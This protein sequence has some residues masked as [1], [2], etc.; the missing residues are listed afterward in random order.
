M[1]EFQESL[2]ELAERPDLDAQGCANVLAG[3]TGRDLL[4]ALNEWNGSGQLDLNK[5]CNELAGTSG[6][7]AQHAMDTLATA[8]LSGGEPATVPATPAAPTAT[9]GNQLATLTFSAPAN[10]GSPITGYTA[11]STPGGVTASGAAS[12]L[13]VTGLTNGTPYTF[14]VRATNAVGDSAESPASNSVTPAT[15][16]G[17]PTI[18]T[19]TAGDTQAT[20]P[21]TA[22][23]SN[24]GEAI[25]GY[26]A[27]SSPGGLTATGAS[28]PLTVTGLTNGQ[29]YTFTVKATNAVGDSAD[30]AASNSVTPVATITNL[31]TANQSSIETNTSGLQGGGN[32][33]VAQSLL[34]A[35]HGN[36]SLRGTNTSAGTQ[37]LGTT[38]GL[39]GRPVSPNTQYTAVADVRHGGTPR[40]TNIVIGFYTAAG[41]LISEF[42]GT[43]ANNTASYV[44]R[45]V[46]A[47][48]PANAAFAAVSV[49]MSSAAITEAHHTDRLGLFQGT[50]TSWVLGTGV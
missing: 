25:T 40:S 8:G 3:T 13:T 14:T 30:S 46:T 2:Q 7:D 42:S 50:N 6:L 29:A 9:R 47:T 15:V 36:A 16:P 23:A 31:L 22:P 34:H 19:A 37:L 33:S 10:G 48:S 26:T 28:S 20:V 17:A 4:R 43:A 21:F 44:Q 5:V 11:T 12:P 24:G 49:R 1:R 39:N 45:S 18:G 38:T 32:N 35:S 41:A 27:T